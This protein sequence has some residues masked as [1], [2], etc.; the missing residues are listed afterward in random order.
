LSEARATRAVLL[1]LGLTAALLSLRTPA[2]WTGAA[3][4]M[5][6]LVSVLAGMATLARVFPVR[7]ATAPMLLV[8]AAAH[9]VATAVILWT[10]SALAFKRLGPGTAA[11]AIL[12]LAGIPRLRAAWRGRVPL[13]P[14]E[15]PQAAGVATAALVLGLYVNGFNEVEH[16]GR[17]LFTFRFDWPSHLY[18]A[19]LVREQGL[20]LVGG[21]GVS[22]V[23]FAAL[24]HTGLLCLLAGIEQ[25]AR[26]GPYGAARILGVAGF[27]LLALA[28][29]LGLAGR[30]AGTARMLAA[31]SPLVWGGI[32]LP[33]D[34]F[35]G[36]R[37]GLL[38]PYLGG[39]APLS[40]PAGTLYHNL[41]QLWSVALAAV[42]L[43][44]IDACLSRRQP[45]GL[46]LAGG[47]LGVSWLVKPS[48]PLALVPALLLIAF[49]ARVP[50]RGLARLGAPFLAAVFLYALPA[51]LADLPPG[52]RFAARAPAPGSLFAVLVTV[53]LSGVV[54]TRRLASLGRR[55]AEARSRDAVALAVIGGAAIAACVVEPRLPSYGNHVW[56][57]AAALVLL[58]P[59]TVAWALAWTAG[60]AAPVA[61]AAGLVLLGVHLLTGA[62]YLVRYPWLRPRSVP[63]ATRG[64][65]DAVREATPPDRRVLLDLD[66]VP[67]AAA[68]YVGRPGPLPTVP[69]LQRDEGT[70]LRQW[71]AINGGADPGPAALDGL[72]EGCGGVVVGPRTE[73]LKQPLRARGWRVEAVALGP[74][75]RLFRPPD[76][77]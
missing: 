65:L 42:A 70:D 55:P 77:E 72:L 13:G 46:L 52:P 21:S 68:A 8:T 63:V 64:V 16:G 44:V 38:D 31:L 37:E 61:R 11:L 19:G 43:V 57:L 20:P 51:L 41:T 49:L 69:L 5:A 32:G 66:L 3:M 39:L 76:A 36:N 54:V 34:A 17:L 29:W 26:V 9:G 40:V 24:T 62:T 35:A 30:A 27:P 60:R 25:A 56:S 12:S 28:A 10:A 18:W 23:P 59:E 6:V 2:R 15:V 71:L 75:Y 22:S 50:L 73:H 1:A 47:L 45:G 48:T 33:F 7:D 67:T 53:G 14:G 58:A 74:R 4:L